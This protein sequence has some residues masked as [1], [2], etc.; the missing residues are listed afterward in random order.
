MLADFVEETA[1]SPGTNATVQLV[2]ATAGRR[3]FLS[4]FGDGGACFYTLTSGTTWERGVGAVAAG[5]PNT[6]TRTTVLRNSAGTTARLNFAGTVRVFNT[7][8]A[9]RTLYVDSNR[10]VVI[11]SLVVSVL[12]SIGTS[13]GAALMLA[14]LRG[15]SA[16]ND[17]SIEMITLRTI[18]GNDWT[19]I[20]QLIRRRVDSTE[21]GSIRFKGNGETEIRGNSGVRIANSLTVAAGG[22][23]NAGY[24]TSSSWETSPSGLMTQAGSSVLLGDTSGNAQCP[25]PVAF[26]QRCITA[27]SQSGDTGPGPG[28]TVNIVLTNQNG[29]I[30]HFTGAV[31]TSF[32]CNWIAVGY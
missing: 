22:S 7:L 21:T 2:G 11:P 32:R 14:S 25:F 24:N 9:Q 17:D 6:L 26:P 10:N 20:E 18:A 13:V 19:G 29:F 8:P 31:S 28:A 1:N 3:T 12:E 23:F 30:A 27:I 5:S 15:R 4:A 16:S